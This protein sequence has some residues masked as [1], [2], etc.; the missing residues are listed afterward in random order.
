[1]LSVCDVIAPCDNVRSIVYAEFFIAPGGINQR[2]QTK[3]Q[4][5]ATIEVKRIMVFGNR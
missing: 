4:R 1:M 5:I 2:H 3:R